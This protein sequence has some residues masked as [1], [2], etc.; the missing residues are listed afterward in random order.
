MR[1][2]D[3]D[4]A[5]VFGSSVRAIFGDGSPATWASEREVTEFRCTTR[6]LEREGSRLRT[7]ICA[8]RFRKLPGLYDVIVRAAALG[9]PR[10][11]LVTSLQLSGVTWENATRVARNFL[12][13]ISWSQ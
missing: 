5:D 1:A 2:I 10:D 9:A 6:N 11:G 13:R 3:L 7:A 4:L 8:R 12:E